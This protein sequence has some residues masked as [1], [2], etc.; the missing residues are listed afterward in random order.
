MFRKPVWSNHFCSCICFSNDTKMTHSL[1]LILRLKLWLQRCRR[2]WTWRRPF[3]SSKPRMERWFRSRCQA[4]ESLVQTSHMCVNKDIRLKCQGEG[5]P[6]ECG[7]SNS[8][9]LPKPPLSVNNFQLIPSKTN[10]ISC[11]MS[12]RME[13]TGRPTKNSRGVQ[14]A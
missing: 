13:T 5:K 9:Y 8:N 7:H 14:S 3:S 10:A 4:L 12:A 2:R 6:K 1:F 11:N